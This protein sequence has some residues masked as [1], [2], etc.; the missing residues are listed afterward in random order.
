MNEM[1][2]IESGNKEVPEILFSTTGLTC[3]KIS[4]VLEFC[5]RKCG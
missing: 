4:L 1:R 2:A 3:E 5:S